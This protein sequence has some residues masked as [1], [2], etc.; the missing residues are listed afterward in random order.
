MT[1]RDRT[2]GDNQD[3][4]PGGP[5]PDAHVYNYPPVKY[6][7]P[8]GRTRD[9]MTVVEVEGVVLG[10]ALLFPAT[11]AGQVA[12][13]ARPDDFSLL[14][15][16]QTFDAIAYLAGEG[17]PVN[18]HTVWGV[19]RSRPDGG[20]AFGE[21]KSLVSLQ[22]GVPEGH[23]PE[24]LRDLLGVL[25]PAGIKRRLSRMALLIGSG[26]DEPD[27]SADDLMT[28]FEMELDYCRELH[29]GLGLERKGF[30]SADDLA[31]AFD[32]R[33]VDYHQGRTDA[34]P[35]GWPEWDEE[36]LAGGGLKRKGLYLFVAPPGVGKTS[37]ALGIQQNLALRGVAFPYVSIEM[38][39]M[40]LVQRQMAVY[41]N[42][43]HWM[44]R[45]GFHGPEYGRARELLKDFRRLPLY[46][47][48]NLWTLPDIWR[49]G[50]QAVYG[51]IQAQGLIVDYMQLV[52]PEARD[53]GSESE[54]QQV[55]RVSKGLKRMATRLNIPLIGIC[56]MNRDQ[57]RE[58]KD[59]KPRAP[60]LRDLRA[61]GQLEFD[62]ELVAALWERP[63]WEEANRA[64]SYRRIESIILKQR[65]GPTTLADGS[66]LELIY[67]K[68]YMNF[69]TAK[70]WA[71]AQ[72][73]AAGNGHRPAEPAPPPTEP[74]GEAQEDLW[75]QAA[76]QD[77]GPTKG[78]RTRKNSAK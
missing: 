20:Q 66:N 10:L 71:V 29:D 36:I 73:T 64:M 59:H 27:E 60:R 47:A 34:V 41:A 51:P 61:S 77:T 49:Y 21:M 12:E 40:D 11:Y 28:Q 17:K 72:G 26:A 78:S 74:A 18:V 46:Y 45:P 19:I 42:V 54:Y 57:D 55:T 62:A 1:Q 4:D 65:N 14:Q 3:R 68:E 2:V 75:Q 53:T 39:K 22:Y 69:L 33:L 35:T 16:Q 38:D 5:D 44:F 52:S 24:M 7:P 6:Q 13:L 30:F 70:Q 50:Q 8:R 9:Y 67:L 32:R 31:E 23:T 15:H 63:E 37:A 25:R 56:S 76:Q 43:P 58:G 48:D